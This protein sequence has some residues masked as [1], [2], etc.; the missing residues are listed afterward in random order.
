MKF[1]A[2]QTKEYLIRQWVLWAYEGRGLKLDYPALA[3][4]AKWRPRAATGLC[5]TAS[6]G[7]ELD[8]VVGTL[9]NSNDTL[10]QVFTL[11]HLAGLPLREVAEAMGHKD[12]KKVKHQL[13]LAE[14]FF[15]LMTLGPQSER[16]YCGGATPTAYS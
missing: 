13:E 16:E 4:F 7:E 5:I 12:H 11:Y 8:E 1:S 9:K 2:I 3:N 14:Q 6:E 15:E 10:Y